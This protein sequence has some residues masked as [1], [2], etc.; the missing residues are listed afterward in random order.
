MALLDFRVWRRLQDLKH[1]NV[2][3]DRDNELLIWRKVFLNGI[4]DLALENTHIWVIDALDECVTTNSIAAMLTK[5]PS[6]FPLKVFLTSRRTFGSAEWLPLLKNLSYE[7]QITPEDSR[8]DITLYLNTRMESLPLQDEKLRESVKANI[9]EKS[10]GSFLWVTLVLNEMRFIARES[11][12]QRILNEIPPGLDALYER[13]LKTMSGITRGK[14]LIVSIL[15]WVVCA[16]RPLTLKEMEHALKLYTG[17]NVLSLE[18]FLSI[19]CEQL[20]HVDK[21]GRIEVVHE[22]VRSLL[23]RTDLDSEFAVDKSRAHGS[24]AEVCLRYLNG[25]EMKPPRTPK[26]MQ[27]Y[28][29]KASK[30]SAFADYASPYFSQHLRRST[31][32]NN[33]RFLSLCKFM[34]GNVYSWIEHLASNSHLHHMTRTAKDLRGFLNARAK[35]YSPVNKDVHCVSNWEQDLI[36]LASQ[37]GKHLTEYPSSIFWLIPP[38]CPPL[39][40]IA[41]QFKPS[42]STIRVEGLQAGKWSDRISSIHYRREIQTRAVCCST[43]SFAIGLSDKKVNIHL[44]ATCQQVQQ[45]ITPQPVKNMVFSKSGDLLAVSTIHFIIL[46][47]LDTSNQTWKVRLPQESLTMAFTDDDKVLRL[48]TK[49]GVLTA[50]LV[51]NGSQISSSLLEH[52]PDNE[53]GDFRRALTHSAVSPEIEMIFSVQRGRPISLHEI[54]TGSFLGVCERDCDTGM[55]GTDHAPVWI[56]DMICVTNPVKTYL[57]ALYHDGDLALFDPCELSLSGHVLAEAHVLGASPDGYVLATGNDSGTIQIYDLETLTLLHKIISSDRSIR[58]LAFSVDGTRFIDIRGNQCNIWELPVLIHN[59]V[60]DSGSMS[61]VIIPEGSVVGV[62]TAPEP[63]ITALACHNNGKYIFCGRDDGAVVLYS[64]SNGKALRPLYNHANMVGIK[65]LVWGD[66]TQTLV[67]S[68]AASRIMLWKIIEQE[69]TIRTEGPIL[70]DRIDDQSI[71]QVLLSHHETKLLISTDA[72]DIT[73]EIEPGTQTVAS[74]SDRPSSWKWVNH[75]HNPSKLLYITARTI[76]I[77]SWNSDLL[78]PQPEEELALPLELDTNLS[79][80]EATILH[81]NNPKLSI[82]LSGSSDP[83]SPSQI[84]ILSISSFNPPY[85]SILPQ[86]TP[87][88][89]NLSSEIEYLIGSVNNRLIFLD[90]RMWICSLD[91]ENFRG[92]YYRHC[93]LPSDWLNANWNFIMKV[94]SIGDLIFVRRTELAVINGGLESREVLGRVKD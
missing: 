63:E 15:Q 1:N 85:P 8:H 33:E 49:G 30:R 4:L 6:T 36:R 39:S 16:F 26:L 58:S 92:D 48:V 89:S 64:T 46:F 71:K 23:L 7:D 21:G 28:K 91:L 93:F 78:E 17:E 11:D 13:A 56:R 9:I 38:F 52:P 57:A 84:L 24:I 43:T 72:S 20:I 34:N 68:D 22:T 66:E 65:N 86:Q 2:Q 29:V 50:L 18:K 90:K 32:E 45:L 76:H 60:G 83:H 77:Y 75:P 61:N 5:I 40:Q 51:I 25:E 62:N 55:E 31:S 69:D 59:D 37:F 41:I 82:E 88:F 81:S 44:H 54:E 12:I 73:Y 87:N 42:I 10:H 53:N 19:S 35:Y 14:E 79:I 67:S 70:D 80:K 94:T 27:M 47:D 74:F 3:F